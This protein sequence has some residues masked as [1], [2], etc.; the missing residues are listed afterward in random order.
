MLD[1][2]VSFSRACGSS[3]RS[4]PGFHRMGTDSGA[5]LVDRWLPTT[6]D[7]YRLTGSVTTLHRQTSARRHPCTPC[8][9]RASRLAKKVQDDIPNWLQP[10]K[11][12]E[13]REA[14]RLS[15]AARV[16]AS[17]NTDD[18]VER[19]ASWDCPSSRGKAL[20]RTSTSSSRTP[21]DRGE[22]KFG[23]ETTRSTSGTHSSKRQLDT[24]GRLKIIADLLSAPHRLEEHALALFRK[25]RGN[26]TAIS[27]DDI[28]DLLQ[29]MPGEQRKLIRVR[30][31]E[32][33]GAE[34]V[35]ALQFAKLYE[36]SLWRKYEDLNPPRF[37][38][39]DLV[40]WMT[41]GTPRKTY[42]IEG[43]LGKGQFGV[44]HRVVQSSTNV[45][46]AMKTIDKQKAVDSGCPFALLQKEIELLAMLDHPHILRLF[47]YYEDAQNVY[48]IT[49]VCYGG[50]LLDIVKEHAALSK[51]LPENWVSRVFSQILEAIAYCHGKGVMHK[52]LKFDNIMLRTKVTSESPIEEIH[53]VVIDV[54]LSELFG[55]Q[56]GK[57]V[58][59]THFAGNL[60]TI[61]PEVIA[62]DFSHKCDI[63]SIGC[64]LFATLN[65]RPI[66][67]TDQ[68]GQRVL[69][70][71]PFV[72]VPSE[73]DQLGLR[74]LID[75]H[76]AGPPMDVVAHASS[77]AQDAVERMLQINERQ[78]P[79]ANECLE[80]S[81]FASHQKRC[82]LNDSQ[83]NTLLT[84]HER[85]ARFWCAATAAKAA[86][87]LPLAKL[88]PLVDTFK[89]IN[90]SNSGCISRGELSRALQCSGVSSKRADAAA[91]CANLTKTGEIEWSEFV[92][93]MLPSSPE[94]FNAA[95]D[96]AFRHFDANRDGY[97]D[98]TELEQ[99]LQSGQIGKSGSNLPSSFLPRAV[100]MMI[101]EIDADDDGLISAKEF[102]DWFA[103]LSST[104]SE[105]EL[106]EKAPPLYKFGHTAVAG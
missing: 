17:P 23:C 76:V 70:T 79:S 15:P 41:L 43:L 99:L 67:Y 87:Q 25:H 77:E 103:K 52:D 14:V 20:H 10:P 71:Y 5:D 47:E 26:K 4:T 51:P 80:L 13:A 83:V 56:H 46:R 37:V 69:W 66:F 65:S 72:P 32:K 81:W 82:N 73:K 95:L 24:A 96:L 12:E 92:A 60:S 35:D 7:G 34:C 55:P 90:Q 84:F 102:I 94:I 31:Q 54:G 98:Q 45:D 21:R 44:T 2:N 91:E 28:E 100:Q 85:E 59:S 101:N 33:D 88:V 36:W 48:I 53:V 22:Y 19:R 6:A 68:E 61:A 86:T 40:A 78:R 39:S 63:W 75:A 50:E 97:I 62:H 16:Q 18:K 58:R 1:G 74:S 3:C 64:L 29:E 105:Q 8:V 49:D 42:T 93:V 106:I 11:V 9:P 30:L 104:S 27:V 89:A 57:E 38:R